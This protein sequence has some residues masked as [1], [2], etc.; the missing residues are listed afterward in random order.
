MIYPDCLEYRSADEKNFK[1]R[2][3]G[4]CPFGFFLFPQQ[5]KVSWPIHQKKPEG[6]SKGVQSNWDF[7]RHISFFHR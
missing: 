7:K 6:S 3:W 2:K 4:K 1:K 5:T